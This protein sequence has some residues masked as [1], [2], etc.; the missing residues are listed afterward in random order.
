MKNTFYLVLLLCFSL[1]SAQIK[2]N[3]TTISRQN[4][5]QA[6]D[7]G[8]ANIYGNNINAFR[9]QNLI[10]NPTIT[11]DVKALNSIVADSY[12]AVFN[13]VQIGETAEDTNKLMNER[14]NDVKSAL[15]AQGI[16]SK[17]II[18]DVISF[19]PVYETVVEKKLFS[20]K[21]NEV[22]KG[23]ELQQN[24]HIKFTEVNQFEKILA[25]CAKNEIYN[26][27]KVDYFIE[28]IEAVYTKLRAEILK[29]LKAKKQFY[30]DLGFDLANY[31]PTMADTKYC[32][33]P[34][35]F[36]K[37][38][39]A[40]NSIS[41]EAIKKPKGIIQAKKQTSYYYDPLSFKEYDVVIN[42]SIVEPVIQIGMEI[43]LQY[44]EKPK[45]PEPIV[46]EKEVI[47]NKYFILS[48]DGELKAKEL[49]LEN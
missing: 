16:F 37:N 2:G 41:L 13:L 35:E 40:F 6:E 46:K 18:I 32:H 12:T 47:K 3:A 30:L 24:L 14:V 20:K 7:L 21:Y 26:L 48:K 28:N 1:A 43:K 5:I 23:F 19:V 17:D 4:V 8:N 45:K 34:R 36:Y 9:H 15:T 39:Q 42:P 31:K 29:T 33:F 38:Y 27:V 11:I 44:I 25:A 49:K 22:P 10:P